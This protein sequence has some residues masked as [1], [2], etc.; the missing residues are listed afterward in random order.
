MNREQAEMLLAQLVFNELDEPTKTQL[1]DYLKTDPQLSERLGDMR[2]LANLLREGFESDDTPC[3]S[4]DRRASVLDKL[5]EEPSAAGGP[6]PFGKPLRGTGRWRIGKPIIAAAAGLMLAGVL[7]AL[8]FPSLGAARRTARQM[9]SSTQLRGIHQGMVMY[10]QKNDG[11]YPDDLGVLVAESYIAPGYLLSPSDSASV[12]ADF[13]SYSP[14]QKKQWV[15][16][17]S[18]YVATSLG[19]QDDLN[20]EVVAGFERFSS[21]KPGVSVV[22]KDNHVVYL[23]KDE[24]RKLIE[25]QTGRTVEQVTE[26]FEQAGQL[27]GG[28]SF[29]VAERQDANG[30]LKRLPVTDDDY[31]QAGLSDIRIADRNVNARLS[32][33]ERDETLVD[34]DGEGQGKAKNWF[35]SVA[36]NGHALGIENHSDLF[37][38]PIAAMTP[39]ASMPADQ[40]SNLQPVPDAMG[41]DVTVSV[42]PLPEITTRFA[43]SSGARGAG[44]AKPQPTIEQMERRVLQELAESEA[45]RRTDKAAQQLA[46]AVELQRDQRYDDALDLVDQTLFVDP[47]NAPARHMRQLIENVQGARS[48]EQLVREKHLQTATPEPEEAPPHGD[49]IVTPTDWPQ[50]TERRL[51]RSFKQQTQAYDVRDLLTQAP[52]RTDSRRFSL[53]DALSNT[54]SG[55]ANAK[56]FGVGAGLFGDAGDDEEVES[57]ESHREKQLIMLGALLRESID[58]ETTTEAD[59]DDPPIS[60]VDGRINIHTSPVN[61]EKIADLLRRLRGQESQ[62]EAAGRAADRRV[63]LK[64]R[65]PV[66]I[67]FHENRLVSVVDYLRNTTGANFFVN[68]TALEAAGVEMDTPI[69]LQLNDAPAEQALRLVLKQVSH[70]FDPIAYSIADGVV[71]ISTRQ[72]LNRNRDLRVFDITGLL[73]QMAADDP[74]PEMTTPERIEGVLTL[75]QDSVGRQEDWA[76]YGG[77]TAE[78][79]EL[80]GRLIIRA[81]AEHLKQVDRL[82]ETLRAG[83]G[84]RDKIEPQ[85]ESAPEPPVDEP[86]TQAPPLVAPPVNPWVMTRADRLSTFAIDVDTASYAIARRSIAQGHLPPR[87][88]VRMEEFINAF[89]YNYPTGRDARQTFTVHVAAGPSPYRPELTLLKIGVRGK[90]I[91]RDQLKPAHL[92]FVIDSS[93]SMDTEDRLP[94]VQQS[95][96]ML[97]DQLGEHDRV[98]VIAYGTGANLLAENWPADEKRR[99]LDTVIQSIQCHG[100]TNLMSGIELGYQVARRHFTPGGVNRVILCSD[101]VANVGPA[102]AE[103]VLAHAAAYRDHGV[104]FTSVGFGAGS[105]DDRLLEQLANRGDGSYLFVDSVEEAKRL[106]VDDLAATLPT[107]ARDVKIQVAFDPLC[108]R[109]YRLIGYENRDIADV[110]FRN[111]AV[112]AGEVGS[113]QSATALYELELLAAQDAEGGPRDMGTVYVRHENPQTGQ[114]QEITGRLPAVASHTHTASSDPRF[115]LAASAAQFAELLRG[116]PHAQ[117]GN[118]AEVVRVMEEVSAALPLDAQARNLLELARQAQGL[119]PAPSP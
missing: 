24:A 51:G 44:G 48:E 15:H 32:D 81:P 57:A 3:L 66:P 115:H 70:D 98:S 14:Q 8:L 7:A 107:I 25:S 19:D 6:S 95:L 12:P 31:R 17:N 82:L 109:R 103:Q 21:D 69:T 99:D 105:Y 50:L 86:Q 71:T 65:D 118:F 77:D 41:Y 47:D 4:A 46:R 38:H 20:A 108:V 90:V 84:Q 42:K 28:E 73:T 22:F 106:F 79:R 92:V 56:E 34:Q 96:G 119:P 87:H 54:N 110:N 114:V 101:G 37:D 43:E 78:I 88:T 76:V 112:D 13:D 68:W 29:A 104:T 117:N 35:G 40:I 5:N 62:T 111:D 100:S 36:A 97:L 16:E 94:L 39:P 10:S 116:S 75:I 93:G 113:G 53:V 26:F 67:N 74:D 33:R 45:S 91:G 2:V 83:V 27:S 63:V 72:D 9:Q 1:L 59:G 30:R 11:R 80:G 49:L 102:D 61:H 89:D 18:S 60:I 55:G 58:D 23:P 52:D 64:L 85:P